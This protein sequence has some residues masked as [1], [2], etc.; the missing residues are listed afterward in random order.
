M[1][2]FTSVT[3]FIGRYSRGKAK[4]S[5]MLLSLTM[6]LASCG[7]AASSGGPTAAPTASLT[8]TPST[9]TAGQNADLTFSSTNATSGIIDNGV[10]PVGISNSTGIQ[11]TP[12][13]TTT[14]HYTVTGPGGS[15]TATATV[16]VNP[17]PPPPTMTSFSA[18]P[19]TVLAGQSSTLSWASQNADYVVINASVGPSP[20]RQAASATNFNLPS[21]PQTTTYSAV[22]TTNSGQQSAPSNFLVTVNQITSFDGMSSG[23]VEGGSTEDDIDP[24]GAVGTKQFMEYVNTSYQGYSKT[25]FLPV[26]PSPQQINTPWPSSSPCAQTTQSGPAI[27]L[28]SVI[29]FDRLATPPRWVIAAKTTIQDDY[30]FCIA[31]SN[32]DD[33]TDPNFAWYPYSWNLD[34]NLGK[35]SNGHFYQPDWP[36]LGTWLDGYYAGMDLID[37]TTKVESGVLACVFDRTN[38]LINSTSTPA[39]ACYKDQ[40]AARIS[41]NPPIY[42]AHSLIP[43]DVDGTTPP[44]A[45]RDEFM[46]SIEN[47]INPAG[48]DGTNTS[49]TLNLWDFQVNWTTPATLKLESVTPVPVS[50]YTPGCYTQ[51]SPGQTICVPEQGVTGIGGIKIDSVGDRLMP[52]FA[53]R[54]FATAATPYESFLVS[55]TVQT[56]EG[57]GQDAQQTGI[58][59]YEFRGDSSGTGTPTL[60]Q[61]N[62]IIPDNTLFRFMPSIA[63]DQ[64]G[65]AAVGYNFS[66]TFNYPGINLS[67]WNLNPAGASPTEVTILNAPGEEI[68]LTINVGQIANAGQWGSYATITVDPVDDCTFWYVNEYWPANLTDLPGPWSTNISY[69]QIPGCQ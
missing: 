13:A 60:F 16:T 37:P 43:A 29:I 61:Q 14:Y 62:T 9:I 67:F 53:Y 20:G 3:N 63:E 54:N 28:D 69:F 12:S 10:G 52:R 31:V 21:P 8:A 17:A 51:G 68:P 58:R 42:L 27:Q 56:N 19:A 30:N 6:V 7:G 66:N 11:V 24:N 57:V 40:N 25:T 33:L 26:W 4:A 46:I 18:S 39:F 44:P 5:A 64:S 65:N 1:E 36:K 45:G 15:A 48:T 55:H 50:I 35:N 59:W 47:P 38:M 23:Q 2:V 34:N 49:S 22:A 41:G 32:T